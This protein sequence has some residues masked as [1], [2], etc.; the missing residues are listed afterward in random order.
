[1]G[2]KGGGQKKKK[3]KKDFLLFEVELSCDFKKT[4]FFFSF[5]K[6]KGGGGFLYYPITLAYNN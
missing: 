5:G 3:N 2:G 1:M 4:F 6:C